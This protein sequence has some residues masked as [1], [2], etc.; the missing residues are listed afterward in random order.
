MR[1]AVVLGLLLALVTGCARYHGELDALPRDE[2]VGEAGDVLTGWH[3][4]APVDRDTTALRLEVYGGGCPGSD[5]EVVGRIDVTETRR[6][7]VVAAY[8]FER[9]D[10]N[11]SCAAATIHPAVVELASPLG[12]RRLVDSGCRPPECD[13]ALDGDARARGYRGPDPKRTHSAPVV[14]GRIVAVREEVEDRPDC[15]PG[16]SGGAD[17]ETTSSAD[18]PQGCGDDVVR[19]WITVER[20]SRRHDFTVG[21]LYR[22]TAAGYRRIEF[23]DLRK[24][25]HVSVWGDPPGSQF[26]SGRK[27][28]LVVL[29]R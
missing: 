28:A 4:A 6:R 22:R 20:R 7:V 14:A 29:V 18:A 5:D 10:D 25:L 26:R 21:S 13:D 12:N 3:L 2:P 27:A 23:A 11:D 9:L 15:P 1:S 16:D 24:G 19:R 17:D 8:L